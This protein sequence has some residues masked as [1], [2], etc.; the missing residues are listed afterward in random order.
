MVVAAEG[1]Y[2]IQGS[3]RR[4]F[5]ERNASST[6]LNPLEASEWYQDYRRDMEAVNQMRWR[7]YVYFRRQPYAGRLVSVDPLGHRV[8]PQV[9]LAADPVAR[10]FLF[11]GSTMWGT[12]QRDRHTIAAEIARR[13]EG[14]AGPGAWIEVVNFGESGYVSTQEMLELMLQLR[15]GNRP[16]VAVF[17]DGINDVAATVQNGVGGIPQNESNRVREFTLGRELRGP[18]SNVG[19]DLK[20]IG[21]FAAAALQKFELV[22]RIQSMVRLSAPQ[23][24]DAET[25]V[26]TLT[27]AYTG[28]VRLIESLTNSYGFKAMYVWQ[29]TLHAS[30]KPHSRWEERLLARVEAEPFDHRLREVHV[31]ALPR[32]RGAMAS[33]APGRFVDAS[34]AFAG[35]PDSVFVD[36]VG[37]TTEDAVPRIVDAIWPTLLK[38]LPRIATSGPATSER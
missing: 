4:A 37:H 24:I 7:S 12:G 3:V 32:L 38:L 29:P 23:F 30:T 17:Y 33:L 10:V 15:A 27:D 13:L 28:N 14:I 20:G 35:E 25:A 5:D 8:T 22:E 34:T 6:A 16:D 21:V 18:S 1:C 9:R 19:A 31:A 26:S 36:T 2:R 11:G